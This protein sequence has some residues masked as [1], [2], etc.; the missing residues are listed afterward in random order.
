MKKPCLL[1][2]IE[3]PHRPAVDNLKV[4]CLQTLDNFYCTFTPIAFEILK[5]LLE[6][7]QP[8]TIAE[9]SETLNKDGTAIAQSVRSLVTAGVLIPSKTSDA[10]ELPCNE[11]HF[12]FTVTASTP[13]HN[14]IPTYFVSA[15]AD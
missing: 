9:I 6:Q 15:S 11:I 4:I 3:Y 13:L 12:D 2:T 14:R 5:C 10:F 7:N 8:K 1:V